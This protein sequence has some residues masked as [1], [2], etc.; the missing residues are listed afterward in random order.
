[1]NISTR[2]LRSAILV[3]LMIFPGPSACGESD[4]GVEPEP[5]PEPQA[6]EPTA[7]SCFDPPSNL[8]AWWPGDGNAEDIVGAADGIESGGATYDAG[9]VGQAFNLDGVAATVLLDEVTA[10]RS[11]TV[12]AWV[13]PARASGRE[14]IYG[15]AYSGLQLLDGRVAWWQDDNARDAP[16]AGVACLGEERCDRLVGAERLAP[17]RWRHIALTFSSNELRSY[18]DGQLDRS[19]VFADGFMTT[20]L[21]PGIGMYSREDFPHWFAGLIDELSVYSR[22]LLPEE[23]EAIWDAG[24]MGKCKA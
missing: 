13:R 1:M 23:I 2:G 24:S 9:Y 3:A 5:E 10:P 16:A 21:G 4:S 12:E 7:L 20:S 11:F 15:D 22:P 14:A 6:P 19:V 18:V 17:D 8:V